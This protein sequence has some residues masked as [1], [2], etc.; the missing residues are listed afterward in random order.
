MFPNQTD[1]AIAQ[2]NTASRRL[3]GLRLRANA[4]FP[5]E[6][7]FLDGIAELDSLLADTGDSWVVLYFDQDVLE[8]DSEMK[9]EFAALQ[10]TWRALALGLAE[11]ANV[12]V[13]DLAGRFTTE[14]SL[15]TRLEL[16]RLD[17]QRDPS[18]IRWSEVNDDV[19]YVVDSDHRY[20]EL[21]CAKFHRGAEVGQLRTDFTPDVK[22]LTFGGVL[23]DAQAIADIVRQQL[24]EKILAPGSIT[25]TPVFLRQDYTAALSSY[26]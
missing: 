3:R 24:S 11:V 25:S 9:A 1:L 23:D 19:M 16:D 7:I 5:G 4:Q 14:P 15:S 18:A 21:P 13:V 20:I 6:I 26:R 8:S 2:F 17:V 22:G 12:A 10:G